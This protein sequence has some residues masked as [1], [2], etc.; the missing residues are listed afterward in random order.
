V[1]FDAEGATIER[2]RADA[3]YGGLRIKTY[4]YV[5]GARIRMADCAP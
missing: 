5:D 4:A 1:T 2:I 3:Q